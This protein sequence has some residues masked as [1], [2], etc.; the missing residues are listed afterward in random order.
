MLRSQAVA[1]AV[2]A[3][4]RLGLRYDKLI[5][6]SYV[7]LP[8]EPPT[9]SLNQALLTNGHTVI[10]PEYRTVDGSHK[11]EMSWHRLQPSGRVDE[12]E[13]AIHRAAVML[14]PAIA[15]GRDGTRLGKGKG[16]YDRCLSQLPRHPMGPL[17]IVLIG[18]DEFFDSVPVDAHDQKI[19]HAL[20]V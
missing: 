9:E 17:R 11:P 15:A 18:R 20:I 6:A 10:V 3:D 14:I 16:Y 19:D 5:V 4:P 13:T 2:L 1:T 12:E 7:S 8:L